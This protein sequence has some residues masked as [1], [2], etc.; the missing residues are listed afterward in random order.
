MKK[1][2]SL[3][4]S[5][6]IPGW[7]QAA[8]KHCVEAVLFFSSEIFCLYKVFSY[9]HR[10]N[11]YYM[12]Y[13]KADNRE[14]AARYRRL[15]ENYDTKRNKFL[16]LQTACKDRL[17]DNQYGPN[18]SE[19]IFGVVN[20]ITTPAFMPPGTDLGRQYSMECGRL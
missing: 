16:F 1:G 8:E 4:K 13:Q 12:L 10:G 11:E 5:L 7:G 19:V 3:Q 9:N 14:D 18:V 20:T 6:L 17:F 2:I 15:T